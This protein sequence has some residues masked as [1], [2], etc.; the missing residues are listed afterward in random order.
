MP[1]TLAAIIGVGIIAVGILVNLPWSTVAGWFN[2]TGTTA[3]PTRDAAVKA[4]DVLKA[5][6]GDDADLKSIWGKLS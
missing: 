6:L 5:Y 4:Y 1:P 3:K 2:G